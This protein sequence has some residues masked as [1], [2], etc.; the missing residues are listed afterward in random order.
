MS[1]DAGDREDRGGTVV[2]VKLG[3]SLI[4]DKS[5]DASPRDAVIRR[6]AGEIAAG[7][8][9]SEERVVLGHGSGSFGHPPAAEHRLK[10]GANSAAELTALSRTQDRAA[11]LHRR[12]VGALRAAGMDVF[13]VAPSS[14][15]VADDGQPV[16]FALE[17]LVRAMEMGLM[18][19][20]YGD[21][22]MDRERG[23]TIASTEA[24]FAR[25]A[26]SLADRGW[27]V[28]RALWLGDTEGV[29][30]SEGRVL[31][32][33]DPESAGALLG[34]VSGSKATD[35]TGGMRHRVTVAV[36]L[37]S[38]GV[39]SWIGGGRVSGAL[40]EALRGAPDGGTWVR[41]PGPSAG[42]GTSPVEGQ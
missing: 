3:G 28:R 13:S 7:A 21:V 42:S 32:E 19:V 14:A 39:T 9:G 4:T 38:R 40:R 5:G 34:A 8:P 23:G 1:A 35:V 30:D 24:V 15:A 25:L 27:P 33:I 26:M 11:R 18:P 22:M 29:Y 12:V 16:Q 37:A 17:P 2:L 41:P 10:E 6:L 36:E 31:P 20:V